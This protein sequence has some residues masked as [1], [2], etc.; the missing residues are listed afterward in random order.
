MTKTRGMAF[1]L[2][3]RAFALFMFFVP[4]GGM[5]LSSYSRPEAPVKRAAAEAGPEDAHSEKS[6]T[7][8]ARRIEA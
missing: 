4:L 1:A 7:G 3:V 5:G 8:V 2:P 6:W